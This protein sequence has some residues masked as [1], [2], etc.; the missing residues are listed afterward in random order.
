MI[1]FRL[2]SKELIKFFL[3]TQSILACTYDA[4]GQTKTNATIPKYDNDFI[5]LKIGKGEADFVKAK[6][7][8]QNW[9]MFPKSWTRI[10]PANAP[11]KK[12]VTIAMNA[13]F[14][15]L[16]W[17]NACKIVYVIDE[18][19]Q[20]GFA[21][22]TL[23]GHIESG[24]ELFLVSKDNIGNVYYEIK[25]FS[26]PRHWLSKIGYPLVRLLQARFRRDSA[27]Q[28]KEI[29]NTTSVQL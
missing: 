22:G 10:L 21:Y 20:Y 23:P 5:K 12:N 7:A 1:S 8:I 19:N 6:T 26:K 29:T 17:R 27:R 9:Q 3:E 14:A 13:H 2:P 24:E 16:W 25:A 4:E 11:I 15:C 28:I 18:P